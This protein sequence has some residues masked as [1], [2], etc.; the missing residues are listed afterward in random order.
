MDD[1]AAKPNEYSATPILRIVLGREN[2]IQL[3]ING[4]KP[5]TPL[6]VCVGELLAKRRPKSG[7]AALERSSE[8]KGLF[9]GNARGFPVFCTDELDP[10][11][12]SF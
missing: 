4:L 3:V 1:R 5:A 8:Q 11:L 2:R 9:L 7:K 10:T 6:L 12:Q